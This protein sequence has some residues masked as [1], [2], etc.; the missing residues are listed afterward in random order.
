MTKRQSSDRSLVWQ[1]L[2]ILV[3]IAI[4][5]GS[6]AASVVDVLRRQDAGRI[7]VIAPEE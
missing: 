4:S 1:G 2:L 3:C 7:E 5:A 6:I